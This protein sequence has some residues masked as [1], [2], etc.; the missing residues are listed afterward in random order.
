MQGKRLDG[1]VGVVD[2]H[3]QVHSIDPARTVERQPIA[4][5]HNPREVDSL[6]IAARRQDSERA[7]Y[8]TNTVSNLLCRIFIP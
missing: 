6:P 5:T 8:T 7:V 1:G 2:G 4:Q 3:Y